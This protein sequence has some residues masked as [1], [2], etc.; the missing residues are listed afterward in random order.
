MA[1]SHGF[2]TDFDDEPDRVD[3]VNGEGRARADSVLARDPHLACT[4]PSG[5]PSRRPIRCFIGGTCPRTHPRTRGARGCVRTCRRWT[6]EKPRR[7]E[8]NAPLIERTLGF[9]FATLNPDQTRKPLLDDTLSQ[10]T[11]LPRI[12]RHTHHFPATTGL[13]FVSFLSLFWISLLAAERAV[14][15][16]A[17]ACRRQSG[18]P[19]LPMTKSASRRKL[20]FTRRVVSTGEH[21]KGA[22]QHPTAAKPLRTERITERASAACRGQADAT[23]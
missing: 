8:T 4:L 11:P 5:A 3:D 1:P 15:R 17:P 22:V 18:A 16:H 21:P 23:R 14:P 9:D 10:R 13:F 6:A 2:P 20:E 12:S 7:S 19:K